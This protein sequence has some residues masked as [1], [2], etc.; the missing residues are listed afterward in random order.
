MRPAGRPA[1]QP[2]PRCGFHTRGSRPPMPFTLEIVDAQYWPRGDDNFLRACTIVHVWLVEGTIRISDQVRIPL[3]GGDVW[4]KGVYQIFGPFGPH[5]TGRDSATAPYEY[6][7]KV[8]G[9]PPKGKIAVGRV[10]RS[11]DL[12]S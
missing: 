8:S 11:G 6:V 12:D 2:P 5:P 1:A 4:V 7:I 3:D 9:C 10:V